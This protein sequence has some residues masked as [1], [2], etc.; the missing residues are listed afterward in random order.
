M[1]ALSNLSLVQLQACA[2]VSKFKSIKYLSNCAVRIVKFHNKNMYGTQCYRCQAFG[3]SS[4]N[5]NLK[6]RC[7]KCP[8]AHLTSECPKRNRTE[9]AICCNCG[10]NHPANFRN[11]KERQNYLQILQTRQEKIKASQEQRHTKMYSK[12]DGRSWAK[13]ASTTDKADHKAQPLQSPPLDHTTS[14]ML[15][16][17]KTIQSIKEKF[18]VCDNMMDKVIL[19][20]THLGKYV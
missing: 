19:I 20:L 14:E 10:E 17:L 7:V 11:C 2:D 15:G 5:C 8:E 3:H 9:P 12:V 6:P 16:I 4:K 1:S 18:S 13:I